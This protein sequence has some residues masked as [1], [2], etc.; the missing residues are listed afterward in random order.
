MY[1]VSYSYCLNGLF[2]LARRYHLPMLD[3]RINPMVV[4]INQHRQHLTAQAVRLVAVQPELVQRVFTARVNHH[5]IERADKL[6]AVFNR[7]F[8]LGARL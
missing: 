6:D 3:A 2:A 4:C 8:A 5:L 1:K 7:P